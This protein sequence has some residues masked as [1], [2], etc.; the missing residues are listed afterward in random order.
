MF[1]RITGYAKGLIGTVL[2]EF[3]STDEAMKF[4]FLGSIFFL[5]IGVYWTIRPLKDGIFDQIVGLANYQPMAKGLSLIIVFPL[6]ILYS[7]LIDKFSR[8]KVFYI[9]IGIY[10][11]AALL[12]TY[13]FMNPYYGVANTAASPYRML[14]WLW[15]VYV[16]SFGSLIVALFWAFTTDTTSPNAA[17][18]CFPIIALCGQFGNM[19]GPFV[20]T[21]KNYG[22]KTSAP[23][24]GICGL[25]MILTGVIFWL[26]MHSVSKD[27]WKGYHSA[28]EEEA[29]SEPGFFEGLKLLFTKAYLLGIL[30]VITIYEIIL[31]TIDFHFKASSSTY[32]KSI[33]APAVEYDA[34]L[35]RYAY[36]TGVVAF[37]CVLFG[38]SNI[39]KKVGLGF[40]LLLL[41]ILICAAVTTLW[42]YPTGIYIA[43]WVMVVSKA[44]N[45]ALNQPTLKQLYI[46]T[47]KDTRYKAQAWIEMFG[48]RG[49]KGISSIFNNMRSGFV[50]A[51]GQ[52]PGGIYF[53]N[54]FALI[55]FGLL[56]FW[57]FAAIYLAKTYNKAIKD[58]S[59]VC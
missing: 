12:F 47:K 48:S 30:F 14:G 44:I 26:M 18:R 57:F 56:P 32:F 49:S 46:P 15:Y 43:F 27:Q 2:P 24:V 9:L 40:S 39:Q 50:K 8:D 23:I 31:T 54:I 34:F 53:I 42:T 17:R 5:I 35:S 33:G 19:V 52:V 13:F 58:K 41:P 37:L 1:Q 45:Y 7:K 11:V 20:L 10:A 36:M 38:T 59:V 4:G 6:V 21:A 55:S 28:G 22:W 16:E 51:M 25:L 29:E 3:E